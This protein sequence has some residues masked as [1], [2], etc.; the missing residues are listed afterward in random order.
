MVSGYMRGWDGAF[1]IKQVCS[2]ATFSAADSIDS[3]VAQ[4][5]NGSPCGN[6][7][8]GEWPH[9]ENDG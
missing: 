7:C 2:G 9:E 3:K 4:N 5:R 1:H 6:C 8:G